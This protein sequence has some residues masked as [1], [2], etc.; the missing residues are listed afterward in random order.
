MAS[1]VGL[2]SLP[3]V[4]KQEQ[5]EEWWSVTNLVK[6]R[7][8]RSNQGGNSLITDSPPCLVHTQMEKALK[9]PSRRTAR[10]PAYSAEDAWLQRTSE[11]F[12]ELEASFQPSMATSPAKS[13]TTAV[14][15]TGERMMTRTRSEKVLAGSGTSTPGG[16]EPRVQAQVKV[17]NAPTAVPPIDAPPPPPA[18][19]QPSLPISAIVAPV[20]TVP[21]PQPPQP[22][23]PA[24]PIM[25]S[26]TL[27]P[28]S[29][30]PPSQP[31]PP[32]FKTIIL[33]PPAAPATSVDTPPSTDPPP[34]ASEAAAEVQRKIIL[35]FRV[36]NAPPP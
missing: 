25:P 21:S 24:A 19:T 29:V 16:V 4:S 15:T 22:P 34:T 11:V 17:E 2:S 26:S 6:V 1:L 14:R 32:T 13:R 5:R 20:N 3:E 7:V 27:P 8:V 31:V 10:P 28:P 35:K 36:P 18:T 30:T 9:R 12:N 23:R 33:H